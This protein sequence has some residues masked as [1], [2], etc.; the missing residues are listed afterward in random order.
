MKYCY[1]SLTSPP[2]KTDI[3]NVKHLQS[4]YKIK[5]KLI[6]NN[7]PLVLC[8]EF[9]STLMAHGF[10]VCINLPLALALGRRLEMQETC[11]GQNTS[12]LLIKIH[13]EA[14]GFPTPPF[15]S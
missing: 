10:M 3:R 2:Q 5:N 14:E 7:G 1:Y 6:N 13:I 11:S 9:E 12:Y 8:Q 4:I 15:P